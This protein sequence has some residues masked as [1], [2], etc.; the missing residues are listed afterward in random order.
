MLVRRIFYSAKFSLVLTNE[1]GF[2]IPVSNIL[3]KNF[4]EL[5]KMT[6]LKADER[7]A[8]P[9]LLHKRSM[10]LDKLNSG[11]QDLMSLPKIKGNSSHSIQDSFSTLEEALKVNINLKSLYIIHVECSY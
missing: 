11:N 4:L 7:R 10:S 5:H 1:G 8:T 9:S 6:N 3:L 2:D